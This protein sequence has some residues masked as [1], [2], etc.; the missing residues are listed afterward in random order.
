MAG[1]LKK[2]LATLVAAAWL[3]TPGLAKANQTEAEYLDNNK[4]VIERVDYTTFRN[5]LDNGATKQKI[6]NQEEFLQK[7][8]TELNTQV[9][10]NERTGFNFN[11]GV[12]EQEFS[13]FIF[14]KVLKEKLNYEIKT[15]T[16]LIVGLNMALEYLTTYNWKMLLLG[17]GIGSDI[18]KDGRFDGVSWSSLQKI[19]DKLKKEI[20]KDP[21]KGPELAIK[22]NI[23]TD[24]TPAD[25][26]L[27]GIE[28][29]TMG[30]DNNNYD[31]YTPMKYYKVSKKQGEPNS[32]EMVCRNLTSA[33]QV[34]F[35]TSKKKYPELTKDIDMVQMMMPG[36]VF[37]AFV[38]KK[39]LEYIVV[40]P[41]WHDYSNKFNLKTL[42]FPPDEEHHYDCLKDG[43]FL[44]KLNFEKEIMA[45]Y[46]KFVSEPFSHKGSKKMLKELVP[47]IRELVKKYPDSQELL[48]L[49]VRTYI[50]F[51]DHKDFSKAYTLLKEVY[52]DE[53]KKEKLDQS[54]HYLTLFYLGCL[55]FELKDYEQAADFFEECSS[56]GIMENNFADEAMAGLAESNL[57]LGN[58]YEALFR[59]KDVLDF[60]PDHYKQIRKDSEKV[61]SKASKKL[62]DYKRRSEL[63]D[64]LKG[65][66]EK[67]VE[68]LKGQD[69]E[70]K[71]LLAESYSALND[72]EKAKAIYQELEKIGDEKIASLA[73]SEMDQMNRKFF[74][75]GYVNFFD[76]KY[77]QC[78]QDFEFLKQQ[79]TPED[80]RADRTSFFLILSYEA[81]KQ[82]MKALKEADYFLKTFPE[83]DLKPVIEQ[84][85]Q[86]IKQHSIIQLNK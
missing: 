36:H 53:E 37:A 14:E 54:T 72:Y 45:Y 68:S 69:A 63:S 74:M 59:A 62:W 24:Y 77:E 40:D 34:M 44:Q 48:G 22:E 7:I 86:Q 50:G 18:N 83:S 41:T 5:N 28:E 30:P 29:I 4:K 70:T 31:G 78:V 27:M 71:L 76:Q 38:N 19:D 46:Q 6:E 16:D 9:F 32:V 65:D 43:S 10:I 39:T 20:I 51:I 21:K 17:G 33:L 85:I 35:E 52:D 15:P 12:N 1:K 82:R 8:I 26:L 61:V 80:F 56:I 3:F 47:K 2:T 57:E 67:A 55:A 23:K 84:Y 58:Y 81:V 13:D 25:M 60:L 75:Y 66:Y 11:R 64:Y 79:M 73:K 42:V 49:E